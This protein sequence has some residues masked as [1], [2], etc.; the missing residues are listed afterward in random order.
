MKISKLKYVFAFMLV[1]TLSVVGVGNVKAAKFDPTD[2]DVS[3]FIQMTEAIVDGDE[4]SQGG[5]TTTYANTVAVFN[6]TYSFGSY[7]PLHF[8]AIKNTT[9]GLFTKVYSLSTTQNSTTGDGVEYTSLGVGDDVGLALAFGLGALSPEQAANQNALSTSALAQSAATQAYIWDVRNGTSYGT[10][11]TGAAKTAYDAIATKV[12]KAKQIPSYT[13]A[14]EA[15]SR[16]NPIEMVWNEAAGRYEATVTDSQGLDTTD[17]INVII[18]TQPDIHYTKNGNSVTFFTTS[19]IGTAA[20]PK[21][22]PVYRSINNGVIRPGYATNS[23]N[24][25]QFVYLSASPVAYTDYVSYIS[26]YTN[27]L[28]VKVVKTLASD[29]GKTTNKGDATVEGAVYGIYEDQACSRKVAELITDANGTATSNP[30]EYKNYWVKEITQAEGCKIDTTVYD[31]TTGSA[32]D[33]NGQKVITINSSERIIYGGMRLIVSIS[34]LSGSTTKNPSVGSTIELVLDSDEDNQRYT[35]TVDDRGYAEFTDIPYGHYTCYETSRPNI[36]HGDVQDL[37]DPMKIFIDREETYI[38]SK[39]VNTKTAER[40]IRMEIKD[41]GTNKFITGSPATFKI[42]DV[43]NQQYV[44]QTVTYSEDPTV[45]TPYQTDTFSTDDRGYVVTAE[46]LPAGDYRLEEVTAP[47]GYYNQYAAT[48]TH[49]DFK[50]TPNSTE[51]Y[52]HEDVVVTVFNTPQIHEVEVYTTGDVLSGTNE[53]TEFG[54]QTNNPAYTTKA[55]PG[56]KYEIRALEDVY[57]DDGTLRWAAGHVESY[58]TDNTGMFVLKLYAGKYSITQVEVPEGYVLDSTP[59]EF[60]YTYQSQ[61]IETVKEPRITYSLTRQLYNVIMHK[62]F[63]DAYY[64]RQTDMEIPAIDVALYQDVTFGI[65]AKTDIKN[66]L[67]ETI[68]RANELVNVINVGVDGVATVTAD[69]PM[70]QFYAKE[71]TTNENYELNETHLDIN[72]VPQNKTEVSFDIDAG[73]VVNNPLKVTKVTLIKVEDLTELNNRLDELAGKL[74]NGTTGKETN[75]KTVAKLEGAVYK[76]F[77]EANGS[78]YPLLE[79]D[80][81]TGKLKEVVRTTD[82]DGEIYMEGLPF[83]SYAVQEV[84]APRYYNLDL[85]KEKRPVKHPFSVTKDNPEFK[86][87]LYDVRTLVD[88]TIVVEDE[89][90]NLLK[91]AVVTLVDTDTDN[92]Y[93]AETDEDGVAT[94]EDVRAGRYIRKVSGLEEQYVVPEDKEFYIEED[95]EVLETVK[96]RFVVGNIVVYKTDDETGEPVPGCTFQVLDYE[97]GDVLEEQVTD[98]NGYARFDGYRY[99]KYLVQ[100]SEAA[101]DYEKSDAIMEVSIVEDGVDVVV[102]FTNVYTADIAV[103]LYVVVA[104]VSVFAIVKVAK[105]MKRD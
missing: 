16:Q 41:K 59:Q 85:D 48:G 69:L 64:Y 8:Y 6:S 76:V 29:P 82:E 77:F 25:E 91:D 72:C 86:G 39:L 73:K 51:N 20:N 38:Y 81:T 44:V 24:G 11:L 97:T 98:E 42:Y 63:G 45:H 62:Q 74:A 100:E 105:K 68:I 54:N 66:T 31:A 17:L 22:I 27:A 103:A 89:D 57:T 34:D 43:Q 18:E 101:E 49:V 9:S 13:Y 80:E 33:E 55:I 4:P 12:T 28:R 15:T 56:A 60:E 23:V 78:Y 2:V 94:F 5:Q 75:H 46:M 32:K 61:L 65:Y 102:A 30:L 10:E 14:S 7:N 70:G 87:M 92:V 3:D 71:L 99:G 93:T 19:Q 47:E 52:E 67:G 40:Y 35:T 96:V 26:L 58:T 84:E 88:F 37:M 53:V 1:V 36:E 104:L 95:E 21:T 90:G 83:G 50:V 79:K